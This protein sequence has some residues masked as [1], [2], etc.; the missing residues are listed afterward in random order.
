MKMSALNWKE[1]HHET[2]SR[3]GEGP[4]TVL[5]FAQ[6]QNVDLIV[7]A[8]HRRDECSQSFEQSFTTTLVQKTPCPVLVVHP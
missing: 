2:L 6:A 5:E 8:T 7:V 4:E 1:I 3:P